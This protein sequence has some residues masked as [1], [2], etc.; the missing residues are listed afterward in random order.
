MEETEVAKELESISKEIEASLVTYY[1]AYSMRFVISLYIYQ[2]LQAGDKRK[3]GKRD[4][5]KSSQI[6]QKKNIYHAIK[7]V[8]DHS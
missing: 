2:R 6:Q 3:I 5:F 8:S 1:F 4:T 7:T